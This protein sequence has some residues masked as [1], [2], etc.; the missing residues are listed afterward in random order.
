[1]NKASFYNANSIRLLIE[2]FSFD[3]FLMD[4]INVGYKSSSFY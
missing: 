2:Y 3:D 1:M 4:C